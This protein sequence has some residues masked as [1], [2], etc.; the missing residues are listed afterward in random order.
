MYA[1]SFSSCTPCRDEKRTE[2]LRF[3]LDDFGIVHV[4]LHAAMK[5]GLKAD[6][7]YRENQTKRQ[8]ALHAAMKSGLKVSPIFAGYS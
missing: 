8:V 6:N 5:S 3:E 1:T 4:A 2:R 7:Y